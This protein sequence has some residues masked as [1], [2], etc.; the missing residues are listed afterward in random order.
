MINFTNKNK[1]NS[2]KKLRDRDKN[3][4][5]K[6]LIIAT[7]TNNK[8]SPQSTH[9][10]K[11]RKHAYFRSLKEKFKLYT[12]ETLHWKEV[13]FRLASTVVL[14]ILPW[15]ILTCTYGF[16]VS[17]L[18][19]F[20][21][22][23]IFRDSK[24]LPNVV[25]SLNIVL[26]LLLAFRTNTAHERFWEGRKLWGAMVNT[27]RNLAR[28]IWIYIAE[29]E[30]KDKTSKEATMRLVVAFTVAMKLHLR[31]DLVNLELAPLMSSFEY[32]QLRDAN[33]PPLE[34]SLWIGEYLQT[35]H[36][37]QLLNV[38][39]LNTLHKLLDDMIDILGGCERILK[40]PVPLF[41]TIAFKAL[42]L[43]YLLLLPWELV[44]GLTWWTGPILGFISLILLGIDEIGSEIEE[45][46][47]HD[48][49]D[50]PL[51]VICKTMSRN[52]EDLIK[53]STQHMLCDRS[54]NNA[55]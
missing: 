4:H 46:F 19:Q 16:I 36:E 7:F 38:F 10:K 23:S 48:P 1:R 34:I 52:V 22:I 29:S 54:D 42:L 35:Q 41:Y 9:S 44:N 21:H 18:Y 40:T 33:H 37:R 5:S 24:V 17:S 27:V 39:Q 43:I 13:T 2:H 53:T 51:D 26:S 6:N 8:N 25:L 55:A 20:G 45:P 11:S 12:G 49:N 15:V 30:P 31:R 3:A 47:G 14:A 50:L 32:H 28:G